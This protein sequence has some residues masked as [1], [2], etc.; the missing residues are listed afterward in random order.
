MDWIVY[1]RGES[2]SGYCI[3]VLSS[4]L[5]LFFLFSRNLGQGD[6][7][8]NWKT[9]KKLLLQSTIQEIPNVLS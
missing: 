3:A 9:K 2:I 4:P 5:L 8:N 7:Q 1:D 6:E